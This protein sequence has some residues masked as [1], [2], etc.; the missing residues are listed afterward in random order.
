[1][2]QDPRGGANVVTLP[3]TPGR[4]LRRRVLWIG[5]SVVAVIVA[6]MLVLLFSPLLAVQTI[7]VE[8]NKLVPSKTINTA[9]APLKGVPL[10]RIGP[11]QVKDLL[12]DQTPIQDVVVQAHAPGTLEVQIVE[13]APVAVVK[14]G[15][16]SYDLVDGEGRAL[17]TVKKRES[18]KLPLID[19]KKS[20]QDPRVFASLTHVLSALPA[21]ALKQLDHASAQT[22]DSVELSLSNGQKVLWGSDERSGDKSRVLTA[23]LKDKKQQGV[24]TFD[25]STP[26]HPVT[27]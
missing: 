18:V 1:V 23:F 25:V 21:S 17:S 3:E 6:L 26:D 11:A 8:G 20:K 7:T 4:R 13:Y 5:G 16:N 2:R 27:R 12:A 22:V 9:L 24:G 14:N 10:P 15:A 19:A